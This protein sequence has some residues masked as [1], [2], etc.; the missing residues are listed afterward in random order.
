MIRKLMMHRF[1]LPRKRLRHAGHREIGKCLVFSR[2]EDVEQHLEDVDV[3]DAV[4]VKSDELEML[5]KIWRMGGARQSLTGT[6]RIGEQDLANPMRSKHAS[7]AG[8]RE[9]SAKGVGTVRVQGRGGVEGA[10]GVSRGKERG[11]GGG[12]GGGGRMVGGGD[13][14]EGGPRVWFCPCAPTRARG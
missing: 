11:G 7:S 2:I 5:D 8:H 14:A 6:R 1:G 3:T 12:G 9:H 13:G 4:W 10:R